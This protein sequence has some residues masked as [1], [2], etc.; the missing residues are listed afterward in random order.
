MP[1]RLR[2]T[3]LYGVAQCLSG[4]MVN[5]CN[6]SES[7]M[8]NDT[9]FGD[10]CGSYGPIQKLTKTEVKRIAAWLGVPENLVNKTP[11]DGLQPLSDE[12]RLGITYAKVDDY[13]RSTGQVSLAEETLIMDKFTKN[14]FKLEIVRIPGPVFAH[15][16]DKI[17]ANFG[18]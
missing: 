6:R 13:I 12:D 17:R 4:V 3:A 2:M 15:Y 16:P 5:T 7:I 1:A 11:I 10:D 8:G 9:L 14:K 18:V